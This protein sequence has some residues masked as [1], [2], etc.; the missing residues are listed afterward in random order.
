MK[1]SCPARSHSQKGQS[2]IEVAFATAVVSIVLVA[3]LSS[4]IQAMSNSRVALE[5]TKTT[6][7][8]QEVVEWLHQQRDVEGWGVFASEFAAVGNDLTYCLPSVPED[9]AA[10]TNSESGPCDNEEVIPETLFQ[11]SLG[12][13]VLSPQE[14]RFT[15]SV[16]RPGKSG[17]ITSQ[18][19]VVLS[20]AL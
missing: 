18:Y 15:V 20:D 16:T 14:I 5:Q 12:V 11:R 6:Q 17:I 3:L 7:Y 1:H 2:L 10:L 9:F 13:E 19:Q 8:Q 4:V